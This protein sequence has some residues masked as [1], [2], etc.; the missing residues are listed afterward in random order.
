MRVSRLLGAAL[1]AAL[2]LSPEAAAA[3]H[4]AGWRTDFSRHI[5]PLDEIVSG[6]PPN[7]STSV[8]PAG[9]VIPIW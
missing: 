8:P 4:P 3:Q 7:C 2:A 5:V 1:V 9:S 6:G